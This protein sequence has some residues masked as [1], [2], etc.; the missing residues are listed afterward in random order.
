MAQDDIFAQ[1]A[2]LDP[3][4]SPFGTRVLDC[5]PFSTTM[6]STTADP[7]IAATFNHLRV[8]TGENHRGQHPADPITVPCTLT[9]PFDGKV[10]DGPLFTARQMEDKWDIYLFDCVLY[11]SRSWTGELVFRATAE[12]RERE[13]ALTVIE[14]SKAK[15]WGDPGFAVRMVDFLVKSH[16]HR[17]P[18]P[19]PLPQALPEDKKIL[20]MYSFSEYGQWAAYA[21]YQDTTAAR[22]S[23]GN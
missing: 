5:R 8:S 16:L 3:D 19:H 15:L 21:S 11:F 12:F 6:I 2:W 23:V 22:A 13:V 14:A 4:Q 18:V 7:N 1:L 9:Y 10:A 17:W 20:A